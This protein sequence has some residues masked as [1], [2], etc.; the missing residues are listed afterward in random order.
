MFANNWLEVDAKD[1]VFP[2]DSDNGLCTFSIK[3]IDLPMNIFGMPLLVDYYSIHNPDTG[4]IGFA[5]HTA[6]A[7]SSITSASIPPSENQLKGKISSTEHYVQQSEREFFQI[8]TWVFAGLFLAFIVLV[9][10]LA[11]AFVIGFGGIESAWN[12]IPIYAIAALLIWLTLKFIKPGL[13][14]FSS[15]GDL[16][17]GSAQTQYGY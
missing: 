1:Y 9:V 12:L 8:L 16:F 3:P 15:I 2:A 14:I 6:S 13:F 17:G 4:V 11:S 7:K 5:P 10:Y